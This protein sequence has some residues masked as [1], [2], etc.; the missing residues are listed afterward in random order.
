VRSITSVAYHREDLAVET[1]LVVDYNEVTVRTELRRSS[2]SGP[3]QRGTVV[4]DNRAETGYQMRRA[5]DRQTAALR[6]AI[7]EAM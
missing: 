3:G 7:S 2:G 4:G 6:A 1:M 5:L